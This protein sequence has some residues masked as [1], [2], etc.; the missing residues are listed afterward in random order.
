[1][2][3]VGR[4]AELAQLQGWANG[5]DERALLIRGEAGI[6]K[7]RLVEELQSWAE[8]RGAPWVVVG[9]CAALTGNAL[10]YVAQ[11]GRPSDRV[12]EALAPVLPEIAGDGATDTSV[13]TAAGRLRLVEAA[14]SVMTAAAV[15]R[16]LV[17]VVEDVQWMAR[18]GLELVDYLLRSP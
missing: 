14:R 10:P 4:S 15:L 5:S 18:S 13:V 11:T 1:M 2:S 7:T 17:I 12:S 8:Q 9:R 6:G 16:P 3:I